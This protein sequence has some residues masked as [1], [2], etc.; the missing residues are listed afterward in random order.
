MELQ[1]FGA[2]T[3]KW[4]CYLVIV[5][6]TKFKFTNCKAFIWG[7]IAEKVFAMEVLTD[8]HHVVLRQN[9]PEQI[10]QLD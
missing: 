8:R 2:E 10:R 6:N 5:I 1:I 3:L 4:K 7:N 9:R